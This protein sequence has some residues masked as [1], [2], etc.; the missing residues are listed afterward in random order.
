MFRIELSILSSLTP[1]FARVKE[2]LSYAVVNLETF[3]FDSC[4]LINWVDAV[5]PGDWFSISCTKPFKE[6]PSP[7]WL[8]R[9]ID[10]FFVDSIRSLRR[11]FSSLMPGDLPSLCSVLLPLLIDLAESL[12]KIGLS[13]DE[14]GIKGLFDPT[15]LN[16]YARLFVIEPIDYSVEVLYLLSGAYFLQQFNDQ[17]SQAQHE[18]IKHC[19]PWNVVIWISVAFLLFLIK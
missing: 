1:D 12:R 5:V 15:G 9:L 18:H 14:A 17:L 6:R 4:G 3:R 19:I 2:S 7:S 8:S 13:F 16:E 11:N 10:F